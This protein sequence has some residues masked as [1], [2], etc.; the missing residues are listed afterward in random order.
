MRIKEVS[1][2]TGLTEKAIRLYI[3]NGLIHPYVESGVY[4]NSYM[5]SETDVRELEEISVFR[6]AGFSIFE[7]S[8]IKEMPAKLP[9][10]LD[11]KRLSLEME[12]NEKKSIWRISKRQL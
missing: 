8:L 11:K 7:I 10:L 2:K 3:E 12:I 6:K 1:E 9:E 5:F 4:R